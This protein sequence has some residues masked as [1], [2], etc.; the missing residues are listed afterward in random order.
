MCVPNDFPLSTLGELITLP[1]NT[2]DPASETADHW[3]TGIQR[4]KWEFTPVYVKDL[5]W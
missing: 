3:E 1:L 2:N 5:S 4:K